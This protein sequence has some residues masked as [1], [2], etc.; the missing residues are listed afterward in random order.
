MILSRQDKFA[1]DLH[2]LKT[3]VEALRKLLRLGRGNFNVCCVGDREIRKLNSAHLGRSWP[4]DVLAF[5]WLENKSGSLA[6][7]RRARGLRSGRRMRGSSWNNRSRGE[8][9][10]FLGDIVI[11]VETARRS[12][13]AEGHSLKAE[14]QWLVLHGLL[15]LLGHDHDADH[16]EMTALELSLRDRLKKPRMSGRKTAG[17]GAR[18]V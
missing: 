11:S 13:R 16:G 1:L 6:R 12:A 18:N 17:R 14:I 8:F 4:T 2:S 9:R 3:Y 10:N 15:H 5:P 7:S